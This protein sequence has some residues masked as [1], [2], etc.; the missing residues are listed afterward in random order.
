M[1]AGMTPAHHH[2]DARVI[3]RDSEVRSPRHLVISPYPEQYES[4]EVTEDGA[5]IYVRP[6]KPE[7]AQ[8]LLDLFDS[9]S[10]RSRYYRFFTPLKALSRQMLVRLTQVDYDRHI[11]LVALHR[12]DGKERMVGVARVISDPGRKSA[13]FSVAVGD[14]WQGRGIGR[15]LLERSLEVARDY[16]IRNVRGEVLAENEEMLALGRELGFEIK[17]GLEAG[18][19]LLTLELGER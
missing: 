16:G 6:I 17:R 5:E 7:D 4:R 2:I 15:K 12:E 19:D 10:K 3:V 18:E 9:M 14:P 13:E 8:L 1:A 11:A